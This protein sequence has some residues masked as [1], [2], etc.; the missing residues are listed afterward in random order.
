M[1]LTFKVSS[2]K[3]FKAKENC[4]ALSVVL[5]TP[6]RAKYTEAKLTGSLVCPSITVPENEM[7]CAKDTVVNNNDIRNGMLNLKV[8]KKITNSE[9]RMSEHIF[10]DL[11][12]RY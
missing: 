4:P 7:G 2:L 12:R 5:P 6:E 9:S 10:K 8:F 1:K 11:L 3:L